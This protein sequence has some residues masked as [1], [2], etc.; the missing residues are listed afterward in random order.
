[1]RYSQEKE[2]QVTLNLQINKQVNFLT[3]L[4]QTLDKKTFYNEVF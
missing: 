1:M 4:I 3:Q 2:D